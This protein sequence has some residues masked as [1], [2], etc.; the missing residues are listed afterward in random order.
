MT[1]ARHLFQQAFKVAHQ[2]VGT[3]RKS[4][5]LAILN[6]RAADSGV[7][8]EKPCILILKVL[9]TGINDRIH[10]V[11]QGVVV[12]RGYLFCKVFHNVR[13]FSSNNLIFLRG[14]MSA[15]K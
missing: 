14:V 2:L 12:P 4:S 3:N 15:S 9:N 6:D 10:I 8:L 7:L 11:K 1:T 5:G 13:I